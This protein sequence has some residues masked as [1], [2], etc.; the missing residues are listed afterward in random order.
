MKKCFELRKQV[1][2]DDKFEFSYLEKLSDL[3]N[4][5]GMEKL[6]KS[7]LNLPSSKKTQVSSH[8]QASLT[9]SKAKW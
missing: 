5:D 9:L 2:V 7:K 3:K 4:L 8:S 1:K 6:E